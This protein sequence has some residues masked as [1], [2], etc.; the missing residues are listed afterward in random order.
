MSL[1]AAELLVVLDE[2]GRQPVRVRLANA[3]RDAIRSGQLSTGATLPSTRVLADDLGVSRGVVV[4]AYAQLAAEGFLR[5]RPGSATTVAY[6]QPAALPER[7]RNRPPET[8]WV[9]ELDLRA[10]WPDLSAFPRA[11]WAN[12]TRDVLL[13]LPTAELGYGEPWGAWELR[14]ALADYLSRVRGAMT[15]PDGVVIVSGVTQGLT[16][17][18]RILRRRGQHRLAV[19]D[20]SNAVQRQ[21]LARLGM[22]LVDI[23][24]DDRGLNVAALEASGVSTVLC[25]PAHQ[26]PTGSVLSA[27]RRERLLMWARDT[28]GLVIE[29][30]YDAEFRYERGPLGCLQG[31][32]PARV[33]LLGSVSK[34]LAPALRLGWVLSPPNL[35]ASVRGIKRDD[36]FGSHV[37]AQHVLARFLDSGQYDRHLR[38]LRRR[39]RER[40]DALLAAIAEHLPNWRVMGNAGGLHVTV[41]L[42]GGVSESRLVAAAASLGLSVLGLAAM[43]GR[44]ASGA[45]LVLS[46]ARVSPDMA[47]EAVRRLAHAARVAAQMSPELEAT[48]SIASLL[49]HDLN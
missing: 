21:L 12:L 45:G 43:Q 10:G 26:Y 49:W 6:A 9:P 42:P 38:G 22:E 25:T 16:L 2:P 29:D 11:T 34:T 47:Q 46:Y 23:P 30:D 18:C 41:S 48:A 39:Y 36:D 19:E 24:V 7:W 32:D 4:E 15:A 17:L 13:Q 28:G 20:P 35:L 8:P 1:N 5:S 44:T 37:I 27:A 14:R 40:R 31:M 33:V 3:L